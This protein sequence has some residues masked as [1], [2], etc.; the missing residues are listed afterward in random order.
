LLQSSVETG[1]EE[2]VW[3]LDCRVAARKTKSRHDECQL[4]LEARSVHCGEQKVTDDK[5]CGG[6][7]G[8]QQ[9]RSKARQRPRLSR[10]KKGERLAALGG[11]AFTNAIREVIVMTS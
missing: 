7:P 1:I 2:L 6:S 4:C 11:G 9:G 8:K 3:V 10:E 5:E